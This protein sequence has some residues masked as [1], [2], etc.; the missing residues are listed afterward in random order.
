MAIG[1]FG[2]GGSG[3]DTHELEQGLAMAE[4]FVIRG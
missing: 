4:G 3:L 2:F 1:L